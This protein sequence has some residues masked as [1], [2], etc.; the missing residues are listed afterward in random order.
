M[1][2]SIKYDFRTTLHT[3]VLFALTVQCNAMQCNAW[4]WIFLSKSRTITISC[5]EG[6]T[7]ETTNW[8]GEAGV[9]F[10]GLVSRIHSLVANA[11]DLSYNFTSAR[12]RLNIFLFIQ[13]TEWT[14]PFE[15]SQNSCQRTDFSKRFLEPTLLRHALHIDDGFICAWDR[16]VYLCF[17]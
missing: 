15:K 16:N 9:L 11:L 7:N 14:C 2:D 10:S 3:H 1:K 8:R 4:F 17:I 13:R 12:E 6:A 5:N